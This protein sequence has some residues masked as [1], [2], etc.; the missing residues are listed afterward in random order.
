MNDI[1]G[2][3][4]RGE[5]F[6]SLGKI[7]DRERCK[8]MQT[9]CH[10]ITTTVDSYSGTSNIDTSIRVQMNKRRPEYLFYH[11]IAFHHPQ[12]PSLHHI[13]TTQHFSLSISLQHSLPLL[14]STHTAFT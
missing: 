3:R 10:A 7:E 13:P 6:E 11:I 5:R 4:E 14:G 12:P 1:F 8:R 2:G 9:H